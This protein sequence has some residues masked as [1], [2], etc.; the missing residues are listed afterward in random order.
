[1]GCVWAAGV[2]EAQEHRGE[3]EAA[4]EPVA[5]LGQV[6]RQMVGLNLW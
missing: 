5:E 6:A 1:M 4:V 3:I 2:G